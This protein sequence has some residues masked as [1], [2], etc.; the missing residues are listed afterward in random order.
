MNIYKKTGGTAWPII[1]AANLKSFTMA[2]L[3][4]PQLAKPENAVLVFFEEGDIEHLEKNGFEKYSD[5]MMVDYDAAEAKAAGV[6][7]HPQFYIEELGGVA[8]SYKYEGDPG[9]GVA[10]MA[11]VGIDNGKDLPGFITKL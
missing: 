3:N 6:E 8:V 1:Q 2:N 4:N 11:V 5:A 10:R 9:T 7:V